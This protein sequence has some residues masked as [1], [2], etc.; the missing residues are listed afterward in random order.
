MKK[1]LLS[2]ATV[3]LA[4]AGVQADTW[5]LATKVEAGAEYLLLSGTAVCGNATNAATNSYIKVAKNG[6]SSNYSATITNGVISEVPSDAGVFSFEA[7]GTGYKVKVRKLDGT[8][9]GY[10]NTTAD[11]SMQFKE[12]ASDATVASISFSGNNVTISFDGVKD[13]KNNVSKLQYNSGSPR[14]MNYASNQA[15]VQLYKKSAGGVPTCSSPVFTPAT[16]STLYAED[17]VTLD[18]TTEGAEVFYKVGEGEFA[19]YENPILFTEKGTYTVTAYAKAEGMND[20]A[21]VEATYTYD[22]VRPAFIEDVL[23]Y[24]VFKD[25]SGNAAEGGSTRYGDYTFT[26]E[27]TGIVYA[28]NMA[29]GNNSIQLRSST[30]SG[31]T[32]HSGIVTTENK[33]GYVLAG[34]VIEWNSSTGATRTLDVYGNGTAY[35]H[36]DN[37]YDS[38]ASGT[39]L[40]SIERTGTSLTVDNPKDVFAGLRSNDGAMFINK[41]TLRWLKPAEKKDFVFDVDYVD[42]F[43]EGASGITFKVNVPEDMTETAGKFSWSCDDTANV[44][45][46]VA[47]ERAEVYIVES[48][49]Y[50]INLAFAGDDVY[51]ANK[52]YFLVRVYPDVND[53][54]NMADNE[55]IAV[56]TG[57]PNK[58]S[59]QYFIPNYDADY[60]YYYLL[61][62]TSVSGGEEDGPVLGV[63]A[64]HTAYDHATGITLEGNGTLS[65]IIEKNGVES[66]A[67]SFSYSITTGI[68]SNEADAQ[69]ARFFTID[70]V[71]VSGNEPGLYIRVANGKAEKVIR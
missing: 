47:D 71:E 48:G 3:A 29:T 52:T 22:K 42:Q 66:P 50:T 6:G 45:L 21:V 44:A 34:V 33:D 68:N 27:L 19:K 67:K 5:E 51:K 14:F 61:T 36:A 64:T 65:M 18:C 58:T 4:T 70:G 11:K 57:D 46:G 9:V 12:N 17:T 20:S 40:G 56:E 10:Y 59:F 16:G 30:S 23:T 43:A 39:N 53:H 37:L 55:G 54:M 38:D 31:S 1:L 15:A 24:N 60:N 69:D 49:V 41:I 8:A 28:A 2:L 63:P 13:K 32:I 7:D 35:S 26:S 25:A 62:P